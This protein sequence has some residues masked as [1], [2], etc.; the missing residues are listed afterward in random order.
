MQGRYRTAPVRNEPRNNAVL[1]YSLVGAREGLQNAVWARQQIPDRTTW[2]CPQPKG[3]L[4]SG[5]AWYGGDSPYPT[6]REPAG[7]QARLVKTV[8][9]Q[10]G[11]AKAALEET[12]DWVPPYPG[13]SGRVG[14]LIAIDWV[15]GRSWHLRAQGQLAGEVC[16]HRSSSTCRKL[17][18]FRP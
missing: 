17:R 18:C 13:H 11:L 10:G 6:P 1:W 16:T 7:R 8:N 12:V 3:L 9:L 4:V 2:P 5:R 15:T 14:G